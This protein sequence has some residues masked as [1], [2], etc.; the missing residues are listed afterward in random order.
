MPDPAASPWVPRCLRAPHAAAYVGVSES[1]W[2]A[3]VRAGRAPE[4]VRYG[5]AITVW[6][7]EDLDRW[8]DE[9]A[10]RIAAMPAAN[11][12]HAAP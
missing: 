6:L 11:P 8:I 12:W 5:R 9:R 2:L 4:P 10:G 3:E 7:R 1:W